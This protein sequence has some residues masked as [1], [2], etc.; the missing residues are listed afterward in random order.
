MLLFKI[1][2]TTNDIG[3]NAKA[4]PC[5]AFTLR[6]FVL[7]YPDRPKPLPLIKGKIDGYSI[8]ICLKGAMRCRFQRGFSTGINIKNFVHTS[9]L[10]TFYPWMQATN[11]KVGRVLLC[12]LLGLLQTD[13]RAKPRESI[14][15]TCSKSMIFRCRLWRQRA[16]YQILKLNRGGGINPLGLNFQIK[17]SGL[18][19]NFYCIADFCV[20]RCGNT[21]RQRLFFVCLC[22]KRERWK[23]W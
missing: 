10:K 11:G 15:F 16:A 2:A 22:K 20:M 3:K 18:I 12:V 1:S 13:K 14:K 23:T 17:A 4:A 5:V 7:I 19:N 8:L 9:R 6:P 21:R